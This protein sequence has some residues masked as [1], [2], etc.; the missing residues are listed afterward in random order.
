MAQVLKSLPPTWEMQTEFT[1]PGFSLASLQLRLS[2]CFSNKTLWSH[3]C[4]PAE[5]LSSGPDYSRC[6]TGCMLTPQV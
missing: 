1:A 2:L 4:T 3:C 6:L 5:S